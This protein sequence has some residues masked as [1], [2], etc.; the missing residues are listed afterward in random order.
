MQLNHYTQWEQTNRRW[1]W[2]QDKFFIKC[3]VASLIFC[4]LQQYWFIWHEYLIDPSIIYGGKCVNMHKCRL[5]FKLSM[6][7]IEV[8]TVSLQ[9]KVTELSLQCPF[10]LR[11]LQDIWFNSKNC[12]SHCN[13][14]HYSRLFSK[15][16]FWLFFW[17]YQ[18]SFYS[19]L[20]P[21]ST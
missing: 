12:S 2:M 1:D 18:S 17:I 21:L 6:Q 16:Y 4:M 20:L 5:Q 11:L 10:V 8:I 3:I 13:T 9:W 14:R 15:V 19:R 7:Y